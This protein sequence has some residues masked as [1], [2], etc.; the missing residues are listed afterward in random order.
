MEKHGSILIVDDDD[1]I[2]VAGRL[3]LKR[4]F[5]NVVTISEPSQIA[6]TMKET[7]FDAILLD[8]NFGPG[9]SS[10]D[11]GFHWLAEILKID[12]EAVVIMITAHGGVNIAV[13]AMKMGATDFV[14][15]PWQN[16]KVVATLSAAVK[17]RDS[18]SKAATLKQANRALV[19]DKGSQQIIG[20]SSALK[21]IQLMIERAAPTDANVLIVGENGT[22]K[23]L[24]AREL[25]RLS[26][27]NG[28]IFLS[29]DMGAI[30]ESLF[31]SELFGHKRGSFTDAKEDR[32]GRLHAASGGT[33]FL[34]EIGNLPLHL[35]A[36]LL[37]VLEQRKVTPVG[38]N[39][40]I[41]IDVR[42]IAATNL[43]P[44]QL[45][46]E[47][48]FRQDLLFRLNTVEICVPPLRERPDDI[49]EIANYY[50]DLYCR[51]YDKPLKTLSGQAL[52]AIKAYAWPGNVRALRHAIER[53]VILSQGTSFTASDFALETHPGSAG[54]LENK[55]TVKTGPGHEDIELPDGNLNLERMEYVLIERSLKKHR[56][57]ISHAAKE[58]GLT[59][60]ALYRRM[61]K[62]GF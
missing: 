49:E 51:K 34:D 41:P 26:N 1:D 20:N 5:E 46:D 53:A 16:E 22:G 36:K 55:I 2:L 21:D 11:E 35:Q 48:R 8:M 9:Q 10:G 28:E 45:S 30:S 25:H 56:Y 47:N 7:E 50:I 27:R 14:S 6:A 61:E 4:H 58:L 32:V 23:E 24:V 43:T 18:R 38:S 60:A 29:V 62:Y 52:A 12:P 37:T 42:V 15:K 13:E 59:R 19:A 3:L 31:D 40:P 57:N 54:E 44:K 17:L 39:Q 33:L